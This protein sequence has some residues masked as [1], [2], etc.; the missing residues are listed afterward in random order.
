[1][2]V[3]KRRAIFGS[4]LAAL[5]LQLFPWYG[6]GLYL[7]PDFVL[8]ALLFW[9][10]RAPQYCNIG[11][12]WMAGLA[13]DLASGSYFGQNALAYAVTAFFA[14]VYQRRLI[15]FTDLQQTSYVF[16][17]LLLNQFT[18]YVL[19]LF[20]GSQSPGYYYFFSC[21]TSI[22]LWHFVIVRL[23]SPRDKH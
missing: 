15:L 13:I 8:L 12:A 14:V 16:L 1:M 18:L 6:W 11:V 23:F 2:P 19:K 3:F 5:V 10:L 9:M 22:L 17:L 21:L 20:A 4:L 7:R